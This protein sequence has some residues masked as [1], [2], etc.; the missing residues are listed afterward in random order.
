MIGTV[1][2]FDDLVAALKK[3]T[4]VV[5]NG[6]LAIR[7]FAQSLTGADLS[8]DQRLMTAKEA[9]DFEKA[10]VQSRATFTTESQSQN[11]LRQID[12]L[13]RVLRASRLRR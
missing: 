8:K 11:M 2:G 12:E 10:D 3:E 5:D 7:E 1:L 9:E 4:K 13:D 6:K